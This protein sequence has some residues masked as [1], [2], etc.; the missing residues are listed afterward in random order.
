M[1]ATLVEKYKIARQKNADKSLEED[2]QRFQMILSDLEK[3]AE[4]GNYNGANMIY[5]DLS[6][7]IKK[8]LLDEGFL[9]TTEPWDGYG[10]PVETRVSLNLD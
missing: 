2:K 10:E 4:K 3:I 9:L 8:W 5:K 1:N 6:G 7:R